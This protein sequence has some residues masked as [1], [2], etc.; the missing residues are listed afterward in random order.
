MKKMFLITKKFNV[1]LILF[2]IILGENTQ[3]EIKIRINILS[4]YKIISLRI[5]YECIKHI[6]YFIMKWAEI[7]Y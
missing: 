5:L 2:N 3:Y 6:I 1:V 4:K 7:Y